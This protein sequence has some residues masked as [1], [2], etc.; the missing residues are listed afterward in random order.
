MEGVVTGL[1]IFRHLHTF[2]HESC[3]VSREVLA[4][5]TPLGLGSRGAAIGIL[6]HEVLPTATTT[7]PL[8]I[9]PARPSLER[10]FVAVR[11]E[12]N[13]VVDGARSRQR[14]ALG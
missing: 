1:Q 6:M 12:A 13:D 9:S 14:I 10:L 4:L 3:I 8:I 7:A 11:I 2:K 5:V